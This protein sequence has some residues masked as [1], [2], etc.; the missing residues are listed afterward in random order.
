VY[1]WWI[2]AAA[3]VVSAVLIGRRMIRAAQAQA[4]EIAPRN[5]EL[6]ARA[7]QQH[8]WVLQGDDRGVYGPHGAQLMHYI[9]SG[10]HPTR[11][12]YHINRC[13]A[14][15]LTTPTTCFSSRATCDR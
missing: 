3:A 2:V 10:D 13:A 11:A 12:A 9:R 5:A 7:D 14:M 1:F 15:D 4:A 6:A 8:Q